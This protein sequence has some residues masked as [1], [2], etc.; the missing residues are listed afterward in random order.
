[1]CN[2]FFWGY[3][4]CTHTYMYMYTHIHVHVHVHIQCRCFVHLHFILFA[5]IVTSEPTSLFAAKI[6]Y[7][8]VK[9]TDNGGI[10]DDDTV[11]G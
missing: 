1:M 4:T 3:C 8:N 6:A 10:S 5:V 11:Q 2:L 7:V 9:F